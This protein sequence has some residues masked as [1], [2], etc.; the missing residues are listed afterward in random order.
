MNLD[1]ALRRLTELANSTLA[2]LPGLAM[3]LVVFGLFLLVGRLISAGL[4]RAVQARSESRGLGL[5]PGRVSRWL[6]GLLGFLVGSV[7]AFPSVGAADLLGLLGVG[8]V[9]IGF[10]FRDIL[11]NLLAGSLILL[12]RPFRI[13]DQ[14]VTGGYEGTLEDIAG[15]ACCWRPSSLAWASP[16]ARGGKWRSG[17]ST[18]RSPA[19]SSRANTTPSSTWSWTRSARRSRRG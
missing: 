9:A 6:T 14:I 10:A 4:T 17:R 5:V 19:A 7:I 2:L 8:G 11:Q 18:R 16:S 3:G 1:I 13:G 12:T 15:T